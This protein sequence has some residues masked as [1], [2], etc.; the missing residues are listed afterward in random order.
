MT[1]C[2][3]RK[4]RI[5][6]DRSQTN[7]WLRFGV[8]AYYGFVCGLALYRFCSEL[9]GRES[10]TELTKLHLI[11]F[12]FLAFTSWCLLNVLTRKSDR[13]AAVLYGIFYAIRIG[14]HFVSGQTASVFLGIG[15][16]VI[17]SGFIAI[18]V[19]M[20]SAISHKGF[21]DSATNRLVP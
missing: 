8:T 21:E 14:M 11:I 4:V 7:L 20:V 19:G 10:A 2:V 13:I 17:L 12:A 9:F 1:S 5:L 18:S 6:G 15:C 16:A 3:E